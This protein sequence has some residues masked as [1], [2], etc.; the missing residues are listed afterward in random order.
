MTHLI[1]LAA[2]SS[3][4]FGGNK[5]MWQLDGKPMFM[6]GLRAL[7]EA[8]EGRYWDV[9]LVT[10]PG[11]VAEACRD[12]GVKLVLNPDAEAGISTSIR[13]ALES[14]PDDGG[15]ALFCVADQPFISSETI[16]RLVEGFEASGRSCGCVAHKG[17][18]GNP[19]IFSRALFGK[20]LALDGDI[21]GKRVIRANSGDCFMLE[22][23]DSREML[24]IDTLPAG[25]L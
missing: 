12:S 7:T 11:P 25:N 18:T 5:L 22:I 14:L 23:S 20:L 10:R 13:R 21:G 1:M 19:C 6:H 8:A 24:D 17:T 15:A 9:T 3:R 16:V 2:G 4:R